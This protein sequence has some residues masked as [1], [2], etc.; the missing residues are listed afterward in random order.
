[1]ELSTIKFIKFRYKGQL[2]FV[3]IADL[4]CVEGFRWPRHGALL[5]C[6]N[7]NFLKSKRSWLFHKLLKNKD[8]ILI[9]KSF[10]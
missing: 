2:C 4:G 8:C 10:N 7:R 6:I 5:I 3:T 1:M 9:N